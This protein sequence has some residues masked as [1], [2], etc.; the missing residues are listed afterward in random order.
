VRTRLRMPR[1]DAVA[2]ERG[3]RIAVIRRWNYGQVWSWGVAL[4]VGVA[5]V[6]A[7]VT[8]LAASSGPLEQILFVGVTQIMIW[9]VWRLGAWPHVSVF[10]RGLLIVNP[11]RVWWLP[12]NK[13][14]SV[15][16]PDYLLIKIED[17]RSIKV[18]SSGRI[19]SKNLKENTVQRRICKQIEF[20]INSDND[21]S[22]H[23]DVR[24]DLYSRFILPL[25]MTS[26]VYSVMLT[27][28]TN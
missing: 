2:T 6:L 3:L 28:L 14:T 13:I 10:S 15:D 12:W 4:G 24:I 7:E 23:V 19:S 25:I 9:P 11:I 22:A 8:S 18:T 17:K 26:V 27:T 1:R 20:Y 5:F 16:I 21:E